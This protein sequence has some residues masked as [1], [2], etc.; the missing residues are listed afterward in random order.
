ML[1]NNL[2]KALKQ[3]KSFKK[4]IY[5]TLKTNLMTKIKLQHSKNTI[6]PSRQSKYL[7]YNSVLFFK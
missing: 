4:I 5:T 3:L 1:I 6:I 2:K 7:E